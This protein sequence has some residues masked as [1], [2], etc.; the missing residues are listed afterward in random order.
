MGEEPIHR[1]GVAARLAWDDDSLHVIFRVAD[2][3]VR[4][5][6]AKY[7]DPVCRDSC[8]EFFFTPGPDLGLSYFNIEVNCGGTMLFW[9]H[10]EKGKAVP[11]AAEDGSTIEIG[12]TLPKIIDPEIAEPTTWALE[13]RLPFAVVRKYC[14]D[15]SRPALDV[16]WKANFYKCADGTSHPHW[17]TWSAVDHPT[18][19]FHLPQYFGTLKFL[20][21]RQP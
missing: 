12:R 5:I 2:R 11:V 13:Y 17:L 7:Q 9:W 6:A 20:R 4:A 10:P 15:A 19:Q 21:A 14:P 8:V 3:Y 1:P 16:V 18:P